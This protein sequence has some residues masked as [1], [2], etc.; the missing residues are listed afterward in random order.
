MIY[1]V[2]LVVS[3]CSVFMKGFQHKNVIGNHYKATFFTSYAMAAFDVVA[4]TL[5]VKGGL[6]VALSSGTGAAFGM[7][8]AMWAHSKI[9]KEKKDA[10]IQHP[11]I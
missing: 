10:G 9:F 4:V 11:S 3:F 1:L 8:T 7:V 6:P 2:S 5:I